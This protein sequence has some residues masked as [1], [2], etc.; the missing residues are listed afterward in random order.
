M[1]LLALAAG[2]SD[3]Q[4]CD[5][6]DPA[7]LDGLPTRLSETGLYAD[8]E[9]R[10]V[11]DDVLAYT[12]RFP[13]WSDGA[14]KERW[15]RLPAPVD[16]SD[17]DD[18]SFP[19]GTTLW[20][21]FAVDGTPVETR[22]L[23]R[24]GPGETEW[25]AQAY[26]WDGDDAIATPDGRVDANGTAHDVP[27]AADCFGCHGGRLSRV[28]GVS[29]V[30]LPWEADEGLDLATLAA[31]DR[32]TQAVA[33]VVVPGDATAQ[34]ALGYLHANC[35]HCHNQIR[36]GADGARCYDPENSLDF[37]LPATPIGSVDATPTWETAVGQV[38]EPGN[39]DASELVARISRRGGLF[40]PAM[41][42]LGTE[43]VDDA[44][45]AMIRAWIE[46]L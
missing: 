27:A 42:P 15:I 17:P 38:I 2:C 19:V 11:A 6:I 16:T 44:G 18:W 22:I 37:H 41:P 24:D 14:D 45:V 10:T 25:A 23:R 8:P 30:Q 34:A 43:V 40:G 21:Q 31:D 5:P 3:F 46:G 9:S 33:E 1:I 4:V 13:L 20:K 36:P 32:V 7:V 28:L 35:S 26:V 39:P 29:A 12:P